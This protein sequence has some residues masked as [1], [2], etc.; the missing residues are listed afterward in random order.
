MFKSLR[1]VPF[2]VQSHTDNRTEAPQ[3]TRG[4]LMSDISR[5]NQYRH[6][7]SEDMKMDIL[8]LEQD[9]TDGAQ[10]DEV[11]QVDTLYFNC[12]ILIKLVIFPE[13]VREP[14]SADLLPGDDRGAGERHP[15]DHREG[16]AQGQHQ[17]RGHGQHV[18]SSQG[19]GRQ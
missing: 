12:S 13:E 17:H 11:V 4:S 8:P 18:L 19:E 3:A 2:Q 16:P 15:G 1:K 9:I 6:V 14:A 5:V 10:N 7:I